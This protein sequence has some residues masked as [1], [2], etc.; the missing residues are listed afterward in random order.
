MSDQRD[1][2]ERLRKANQ[3]IFYTHPRSANA[4][5]EGAAVITC[6]RDQLASAE[7]KLRLAFFPFRLQARHAE[8][9]DWADIYPAQLQSF[10]K[11]PYDVRAV[12]LPLLTTTATFR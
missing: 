7:S 2:V 3:A 12:E 11:G 4:C 8:G 1:I 5:A 9:G 10:A 6:L